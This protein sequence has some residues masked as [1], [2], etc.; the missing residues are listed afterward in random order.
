MLSSLEI[1]N[2]SLPLNLSM[3]RKASG[4][5]G[6]VTWNEEL[7]EEYKN[8]MNIMQTRMIQINVFAL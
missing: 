5:K 1:W 3:L 4:S 7:E 8:V 6:K 2:P